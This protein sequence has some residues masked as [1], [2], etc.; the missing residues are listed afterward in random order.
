MFWATKMRKLSNKF[1]RGILSVLL[2]TLALAILINSIVVERFYLYAQRIS[3]QKIGSQLVQRISQGQSPQE[4]IAQIEQAE[5]VLIAFSEHTADSEALSGELREKFRQ[6]GLGF[7]K[8]WLWEQD[9]ASVIEQGKKEK[10]YQQ[11]RLNYGI[12][13]EYRS[14]E[15]KLFAIAVIVPNTGDVVA[16]INTFLILL[17]LFS[18][19]M[20]FTLIRVLV[21]RITGP[22]N[23]MK[24]F[25]EKISRQEYV[26]LTLK[27]G[28]ELE[29]VAESMD[30]M[31]RSIQEYQQK[32][33]EK[34]RQMEQFLDDVAHD[35][36]TP[37]ALVKMYAAGMKDGLDDGTFLE[38]IIA[39]NTRMEQL[40]EQLLALSRMGL[41]DGAGERVRLDLL[42]TAQ[43]EELKPLSDARGLIP[44]TSI[45]PDALVV[46][47]PYLIRTLFSNLISN[48]YKYAEGNSVEI[49]LGKAGSSYV[50]TIV[51]PIGETDLDPER[52]WEPFYVGEKSRN[53]ALS[54]TGLGLAIVK[55][56]ARQCGYPISC[57]IARGLIRFELIIASPDAAE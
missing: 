35:L 25:A 39:Q 23:Q 57:H 45:V 36:K 18:L 30:Q 52:I 20:A 15:G 27:T 32:L 55:R 34:N 6:K 5:D 48:A 26:P 9:Y 38:V 40:I 1:T 2:L 54:G 41:A 53:K 51:N 24:A 3:L 46:G 37:V 19:L 42:L 22:L 43:I 21:R 49:S 7:Q 4:V 56:I 16:I 8:F 28:D 44:H 47:H 29:T 14:I 12:L 10:L 31:R 11:D 33:L 50:F 13:V 17:Q